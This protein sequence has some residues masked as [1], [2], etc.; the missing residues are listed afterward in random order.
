[1]HTPPR[2]L[3]PLSVLLDDLAAHPDTIARLLDVDPRTVRRWIAAGHAPRPVMIALFACSRWG[4]S[5]INTA[6]DNDARIL[7]QRCAILTRE[8]AALAA[9][10]RG[11]WDRVVGAYEAGVLSVLR[12][13]S[14]IPTLVN[15]G[16][17]ARHVAD[18]EGGQHCARDYH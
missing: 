17:Q 1:M 8:N 16:A 9:N 15:P 2:H 10:L 11:M 5:W 12:R 3:P 7:A 4:Y 14:A 18:Q 13:R 6:A